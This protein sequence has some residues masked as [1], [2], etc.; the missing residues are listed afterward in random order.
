M[1]SAP[2]FG[3]N[4]L[5]DGLIFKASVSQ[6]NT[7]EC[8]DKFFCDETQHMLYTMYRLSAAGV[9]Q[10]TLNFSSAI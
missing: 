8:P 6:L 7:K 1:V 3:P 2:Y 10:V 4:D 5:G 9:W